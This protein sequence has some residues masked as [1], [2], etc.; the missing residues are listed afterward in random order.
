ME[1]NKDDYFGILIDWIIVLGILGGLFFLTIVF[2]KL[3]I[4]IVNSYIFK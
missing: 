4:I 2:A 1:K 3:L